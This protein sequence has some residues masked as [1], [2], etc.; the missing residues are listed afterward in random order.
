MEAF[1]DRPLQDVLDAV[2]AQRPAPGGGC[3]AAWAASL[4]AG[5]VEMAASFTLARPRY[6]GVHQRMLDVR[7]DGTLLRRRL[8]ELAERDAEGYEP[9]IAAL[10]L[11]PQHPDRAQMLEDARSDAAEVPLA[12]AE[13]AADVAALAT[14]AA[15]SGSEHLEGDA[16][17]GALLA[18]G[19][20]RAAARL[21]EINLADRPDDARLP[22]AADAVRRA[23]QARD[24]ALRA[25]EGALR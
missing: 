10:R 18:E 25:R 2:A 24:G 14:E 17:T 12:I 13:A 22:R 16:V 15:R 20:C 23:G 11:S 9:V 19:A 1:A 8:V 7:R 6:A 21:V 4:G 3:S 5:L